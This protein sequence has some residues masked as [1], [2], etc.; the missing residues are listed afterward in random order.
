MREPPGGQEWICFH[1][2][3]EEAGEAVWIVTTLNRETYE[4]EYHRVEPGRYVA[5]VSVRCS[6]VTDRR[7]QV[8][9][10]YAFV[11]LSAPDNAEIAFMNKEASS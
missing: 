7:T 10:V 6:P 2:T 5:H 8:G 9:T 1:R 11:G 3:R 4:V